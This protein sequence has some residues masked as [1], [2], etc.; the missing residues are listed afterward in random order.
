MQKG[1]PFLFGENRNISTFLKQLTETSFQ[2]EK[3]K[4]NFVSHE[5][6]PNRDSFI[7]AARLSRRDGLVSLGWSNVAAQQ[8]RKTV[9]A[10]QIK[11]KLLFRR[12]VSCIFQRG[13]NC[14]QR[15][16]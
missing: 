11:K 13:I 10:H 14:L 8:L 15:G 16:R 9:V 7:L 1:K 5:M 12:E 4:L 3:A 6:P 2:P